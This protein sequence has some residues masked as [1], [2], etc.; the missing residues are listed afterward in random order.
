MPEW[1]VWKVGW[2]CVGDHDRFAAALTINKYI[3]NK[4]IVYELV[5]IGYIISYKLFE[6]IAQSPKAFFWILN[7]QY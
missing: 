3:I 7:Y 6:S 1:L 4:I 5:I 2:W